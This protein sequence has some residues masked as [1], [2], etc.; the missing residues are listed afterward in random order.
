[1]SLRS[2]ILRRNPNVPCEGSGAGTPAVTG[3][4][5]SSSTTSTWSE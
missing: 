3:N 1:M 5:R 4:T 2:V